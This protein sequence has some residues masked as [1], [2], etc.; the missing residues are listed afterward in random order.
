M[1]T[2]FKALPTLANTSKEN[3]GATSCFSLADRAVDRFHYALDPRRRCQWMP[4]VRLPLV[5]VASL[6]ARVQNGKCR[7][8][9][10]FKLGWQ[11]KHHLSRDGALGRAQSECFKSLPS[12]RF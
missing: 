12:H 11:W 5:R 1:A 2:R 9:A 7:K 8:P 4:D 3:Q 6:L 10:W